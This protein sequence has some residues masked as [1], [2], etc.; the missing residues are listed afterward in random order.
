MKY[1]NCGPS[2]YLRVFE[3]TKEKHLQVCLDS[4]NLC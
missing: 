1:Q 2:H 3:V 4:V